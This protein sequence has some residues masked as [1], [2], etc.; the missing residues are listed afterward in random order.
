MAAMPK[1]KI[2]KKSVERAMIENMEKGE[3]LKVDRSGWKIK[4]KGPE[5]L[6]RKVERASG[7]RFDV[8]RLLD[9]SGWIIERVA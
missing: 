3:C 8:F 7:K 4:R 5:Y 6:C 2:G 9:K 1:T